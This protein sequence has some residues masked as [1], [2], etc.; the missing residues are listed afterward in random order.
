MFNSTNHC[1]GSRAIQPLKPLTSMLGII[2]TNISTVE[3]QIVISASPETIFS[4]YE[5]ANNWKQ[6]DPDT[7]ASSLDNGLT[8]GSKGSLTPAKGRT[9]PIEIISIEKNRHFTA[10]SKTLLF[11][12]DFDHELEIVAGGTKVV[13]R[14]TFAGLLKP[15]LT[16]VVRPQVE[17]GLP[18]TLQ[19]L[20]S[21][22]ETKQA[23]NT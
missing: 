16:R 10:T 11:R 14:V 1:T 20:K 13:H 8:L 9:V 2:G 19:R 3:K 17:K 22:A 5:D 23:D 21:L 12:M 18:V 7:K 4:I 15:F 6:W